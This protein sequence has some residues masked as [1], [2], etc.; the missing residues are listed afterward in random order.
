MEAVILIG[1][2]GAGKSTFCKQQWFDTHVRINLDMLRTRN[3]EQQLVSACIAARQ[4]FVVDNT[5]PTIQERSLYIR[6]AKSAGFRVV[7][8]YFASRLQDCA[9][10]NE[11]R[12]SKQVVPV[13][14]LL[15]TH[16]RLQLPA[17]NEG[18]DELYYVQI[19]ERDDFVVSD[20]S[21]DI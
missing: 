9:R 19:D 2:Q 8:Y 12:P 5:N 11:S 6:N 10:R 16:A 21:D 1:M 3:R 15:G 14:G 7:G 13:K 17:R 20:W 18:F 4:P